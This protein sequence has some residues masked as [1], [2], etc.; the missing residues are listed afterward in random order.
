MV[1]NEEYYCQR[2]MDGFF[3]IAYHSGDNPEPVV[4]DFIIWNN[5]YSFPQSFL[6]NQDGFAYMKLR[7]YDKIIEVRKT[8]GLIVAIYNCP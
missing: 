4:G 5:R 3:N 7:S 6:F 1:A 2:V 8:D